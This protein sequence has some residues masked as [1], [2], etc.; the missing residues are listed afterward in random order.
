MFSHDLSFR[1]T[2]QDLR[3]EMLRHLT[4]VAF[5]FVALA[6]YS[7][8]FADKFATPLFAVLALTAAGILALRQQI[9]QRL[10]LARYG[11]LLIAHLCLFAALRLTSAAW[12]PF[13][14]VVLVLISGMTTT[15]MHWFSALAIFGAAALLGEHTRYP[16]AE[17]G[18]TLAVTVAVMQTSVASL[19]T[20]LRW[21]SAMQQRAD[22]LLD[23]TRQRQ[24]ELAQT[25]KSLE[26][27]YQ[28]LRRTQQQLV[29]AQR[30][31][32]EARRMKERFAANISHELRTPL[33]L[34]LGFSEIMVLTPEL[35]SETR[36]PPKL[37]R[38]LYQIYTS[39]RHL[40]AMI[41]DVLDLSQIELSRFALNLERVRVNAFIDESAEMFG[42]IFRDGRL[43]FVLDVEDNLPEIEIDRTRIRQVLLNLLGNAHRFTEHGSVTL[44]VRQQG[45]EVVFSVADTGRGIPADKLALIFDEFY[46]VDYSLSRNHGGAGLGLAISKRFVERHGGSIHVTSAEGA[47]STF[48]FALPIRH[49][50]PSAV[51]PAG[52]AAEQTQERYVLV[53]DRDPLVGALVRRHLPA[54]KIVQAADPDDVPDLLDQY[55]PRAIIDNTRAS[56]SWSLPESVLIIRCALPSASWMISQLEVLSYLPKPF[57][58]QQLAEHLSRANGARRILVVDDDVGFVQLV[59]RSLEMLGDYSV[60]RAYDG[61]QAL[62]AAREQRPDLLLLDLAMP[63]MDGFAVLDALR[64]DPQ[65]AALPVILLTATQYT[66]DEAEA[67]GELSVQRAGGLRPAEVLRYARALIE[68]L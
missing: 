63:E 34:I 58:V 44:S 56:N 46:Q 45:Q 36:F 42:N 51:S 28:N 2:L 17:L 3:V 24:A 12:L 37:A 26:I 50:G 40:L 66:R 52:G 38:D 62:A 23:E 19:Y 1:D 61:R 41:D 39:S 25:V 64:A 14:G 35:Y 22:A 48:T 47:G 18:A 30:Q 68:Q 60:C 53:V 59:Q 43:R 27:A 5:V 32:D 65:T 33:N 57:S 7:L 10:N 4:T 29:Y 49:Y 11:L 13:L 67:Y 20:A 16:L 55:H 8:F 21:Y 15:Y 9:P 31:A 6:A 54:H